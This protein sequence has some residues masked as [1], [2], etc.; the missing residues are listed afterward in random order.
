LARVRAKINLDLALQGGGAH[1]AFTWGVLDRLLED[2]R[3]H[4]ASISGASAGAMNAVV[5]A[6][7][8]VTGGPNEAKARLWSFWKGVNRAARTSNPALQAAEAFPHFFAASTAWW[9]LFDGGHVNWAPSPSTGEY[10]QRLLGDVV[11]DHVD[12]AALK[13]G[14]APRLFISATEARTGQTSIFRNSDLSVEAVLASACLPMV[15]PPVTIDGTDYWDGGYSANPPLM[16]LIAESPHDDLLLVTINPL[17][18]KETPTT[19]AE[20]PGRISEMTFNQS[21]IKDVRALSAM[22]EALGKRVPRNAVPLIRAIHVLRIHEIHNEAGFEK[23]DPRTKMLPEWRLLTCLR[24]SGRRAASTW[25]NTS[26]K[27]LGKR[28]TADLAERYF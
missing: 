26:H 22:K 18:R 13:K 15:F 10:A 28:S 9:S 19:V 7:G 20:I 3:L 12:F 27:D 6:S 25:L 8:L 1:G 23:L 4:L 21:L 11:R 17:H 16:P 2:E 5:L 24:K 14:D